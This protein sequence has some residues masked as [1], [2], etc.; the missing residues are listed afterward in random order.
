MSLNP[1]YKCRGVEVRDALLDSHNQEH[2]DH[3]DHHMG[4]DQGSDGAQRVPLEAAHDRKSLDG[5]A[6]G[7]RS[8]RN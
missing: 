5:A 7:G 1:P 3:K 8:M 2:H 6:Y 4:E